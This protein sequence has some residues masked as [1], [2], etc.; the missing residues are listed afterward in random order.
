MKGS[1][2]VNEMFCYEKDVLYVGEKSRKFPHDILDVAEY[3]EKLIVLLE[4]PYESDDINNIYCIDKEANICWQSENLEKLY[5][6]RSNL[7]YERI[8]V[9]DSV[10]YA[11]DF[12]GR[13]YH[14]SPEDGKIED[15][16]IVK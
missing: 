16:E 15:M 1:L 2:E 5:P 12:A 14:I 8:R 11:T 9:R 6:E 7:P 13:C 10:V 3:G 4:I